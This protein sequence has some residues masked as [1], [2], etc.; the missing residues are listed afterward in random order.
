[1]IWGVRIVV[2]NKW[3][4]RLIGLIGAARTAWSVYQGVQRRIDKEIE[5][6][7]G[8][9]P[10][11]KRKLTGEHKRLATGAL[12][13]FKFATDSFT[14]ALRSAERSKAPKNGIL[15]DSDAVTEEMF[16]DN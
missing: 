1:M 6:H 12:K 4:W 2:S 3:F 8:D 15:F 14:K 5:E 16:N 13:D 7:I 9:T 10:K 11:Q